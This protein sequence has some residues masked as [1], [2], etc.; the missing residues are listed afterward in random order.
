MVGLDVDWAPL[1]GKMN[2]FGEKVLHFDTF[3]SAGPDAIQYHDP[4]AAGAAAFTFGGHVGR[5]AA[6]PLQPMVRHPR[7]LPVTTSTLEIET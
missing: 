3:V 7:G 6:L 1:Y 5:G 4:S 2:F